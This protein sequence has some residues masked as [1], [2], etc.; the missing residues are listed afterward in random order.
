MSGLSIEP[1]CPA[2]LKED[3]LEE[4]EICPKCGTHKHASVIENERLDL[5]VLQMLLFLFQANIADRFPQ[6]LKYSVDSYQNFETKQ[7]VIF[8]FHADSFFDFMH[9]VN[10]LALPEEIVRD[11]EFKTLYD[12]YIKTKLDSI[13]PIE[14]I[15]ICQLINNTLLDDNGD[16]IDPEEP[17]SYHCHS[18]I[19]NG[20]QALR[21]SEQKRTGLMNL[22]D[23]K[24]KIKDYCAL[25]LQLCQPNDNS[26]QTLT[27]K[28]VIHH[29]CKAKLPSSDCPICWT[30]PAI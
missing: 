10:L 26:I 28:H 29:D 19:L 4:F 18:Y 3:Q 7:K 20:K 1:L 24:N 2:S 12:S 11:G 30:G 16:E 27:C 15:L 17:L 13:N 21:I 25:C 23:I 6:L 14:D 9:N 8:L 5:P 22:N